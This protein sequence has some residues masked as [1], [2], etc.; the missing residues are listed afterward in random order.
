MI[1]TDVIAIELKIDSSR[2]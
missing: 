2:Y 1:A